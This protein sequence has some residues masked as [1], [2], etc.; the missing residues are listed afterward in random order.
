VGGAGAATSVPS[1]LHGAARVRSDLSQRGH[2]TAPGLNRQLYRDIAAR[3]RDAGFRNAIIRLASE[4]DVAGARWSSAIDYEKF[5]AAYR[6]AVDA[7]R[8]VAPDIEID[9]TSTRTS[10]GPGP[11]PFE[12]VVNAYP[13]DAWVDYI[14]ANTYDHASAREPIG[15]PDGRKCG[16]RDPQAVFDLYIRPGLDTAKAFAIA[17]GKRVS[18]PEWGLSGG[19]T[20][21]V[22][23]CGG[24]NPTFIAN[25]HDWLGKVPAANLGY[26]SYFEGNPDY[27]GPHELDYFPVAKNAFRTY[28][29]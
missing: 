4:H 24:D 12:R 28:F 27:D 11:Q 25:I 6:A 13:G 7:M 16:W 29:G 5:K 18:L 3:L 9:F 20:V 26:A 23:R 2:R 14:G 15:V 19:G 8:S 22:G 17:H 1:R 10:F 21:Q